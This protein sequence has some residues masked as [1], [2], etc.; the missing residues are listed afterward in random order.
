MDF[1]FEEKEQ[2]APKM[3]I[4]RLSRCGKVT[5]IVFVILNI[6]YLVLSVVLFGVGI[7]ILYD[8]VQYQALSSL[9]VVAPGALMVVG[10]IAGVILVVG[11]FIAAF[12]QLRGFLLLYAVMCSLLVLYTLIF[13]VYGVV[14]PSFLTINQQLSVAIRTYHLSTD[15]QQVVDT[16]QTRFRC[17]GVGSTSDWLNTPF[18]VGGYLPM[19]CCPQQTGARLN[20][21]ACTQPPDST[22]YSR[23]CLTEFNTYVASRLFVAGG[24]GLVV[25]LVMIAGVVTSIALLIVIHRDVQKNVKGIKLELVRLTRM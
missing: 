8:G 24:L 5:K 13:G 18:G 6:V 11:G 3:T 2:I 16:L 23:G 19:S 25:G 15:T 7:Y 9:I 10:G 12:G 20:D 17:C 4:T 14:Y 22:P 21:T 1:L